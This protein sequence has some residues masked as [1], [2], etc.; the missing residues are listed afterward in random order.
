MTKRFKKFFTPE[1]FFLIAAFLMLAVLAITAFFALKF[2]ANNINLVLIRPEVGGE[3]IVADFDIDGFK[4][5]NLI[6]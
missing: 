5:L 1:T 4:S 2:L 6:K 3:N